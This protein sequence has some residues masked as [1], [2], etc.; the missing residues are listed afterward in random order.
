VDHKSAWSSGPIYAE[1]VEAVAELLVER[2]AVEPGM[3]VLDVACGAGNGT[4]PAAR[5]GARVTGVDPE[6]AMLAVARERAADAMVEVDWVQADVQ[7]LPFEDGSFDRVISTFGHMFAPD[8][9]RTAEEMKRV[10][11]GRIGVCCWTDSPWGTEEYVTRLLGP[12]RFEHREIEL[13]GLGR[14][15]YLLALTEAGSTRLGRVRTVR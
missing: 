13:P 3:E 4:I 15:G 11:R 8:H 7:R 1:K 9:G 5:L 14:R 12:A 10:C 2:A 6:P